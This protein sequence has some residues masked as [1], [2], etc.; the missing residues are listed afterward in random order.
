MPLNIPQ[1]ILDKI[2][3][4]VAGSYPCVGLFISQEGSQSLGYCALVAKAWTFRGQKHLFV[5]IS[6]K[7]ENLGS[8][9]EINARNPGLLNRH[10]RLLEMKQNDGPGSMTKFTP[11]T[12]E[13]ARPYLTFPNLELFALSHWDDLATFSLPRTFEHY[14]IPS[15]RSF[16][17]IYSISS[18]DVLLELAAIFSYVDEFEIYH[19]YANDPR[20]TKTFSFPGSIGWKEFRMI[21]VDKYLTGVLDVIS[22]LSLQCQVLDI[23]YECLDDPLPIMRLISACSATL[24]YMRLEQTYKG[25]IFLS[26]QPRRLT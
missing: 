25:N 21:S 8:W 4:E 14:A 15:L 12:L 6:L 22:G 19:P 26:L 24:K 10:V 9:C 18:A 16:H 3:D 13:A 2:I 5:S 17:I 7:P 23:S 1:E 11:D 20:V